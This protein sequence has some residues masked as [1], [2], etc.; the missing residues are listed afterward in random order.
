MF[1]SST[2]LPKFLHSLLFRISL[3]LIVVNCIGE[4]SL[5]IND[6]IPR[7]HL[8]ELF[9]KYALNDSLTERN[10]SA[11]IGNIYK[12]PFGSGQDV[13]FPTKNIL[14]ESIGIAEFHQLMPTLLYYLDRHE[15]EKVQEEFHGKV[16]VPRKDWKVWSA[17]VGAVLVISLSGLMVVALVPLMSR[18]VYNVV[19]QFL[20]ALSVGSLIGDSFL[21]LIPHALLSHGD[22]ES[23]GHSHDAASMDEHDSFVWKALIVLLGI[24]AF[25]I[26]ERLTILFQNS[27]SNRKLK[28]N[29]AISGDQ[30]SLMGQ[31]KVVAFSNGGMQV[32]PP[33]LPTSEQ[34]SSKCGDKAASTVNSSGVGTTNFKVPKSSGQVERKPVTP[35]H[36]TT[37]TCID[38]GQEC[39][40][41]STDAGNVCSSDASI[42][43]NLYY[44][45]NGLAASGLISDKHLC[46]KPPSRPLDNARCAE[47][48]TSEV[49]NGNE[50]SE[51]E[52]H[53]DVNACN[54]STA[55]GENGFVM[56]SWNIRETNSNDINNSEA[57]NGGYE[58]QPNGKSPPNGSF[59]GRTSWSPGKN[60]HEGHSHQHHHHHHHH[61]HHHHFPRAFPHRKKPHGHHHGHSHDLSSVRAIAY[62]IIA[63]DG[64]H[65]F[66]DGIAIGA[67]FAESLQGGLS[68]A[69][70][71]LCHELPHELGDFAVLLHAGMS[72]K[73]ALFYNTLSSIL[74]SAGMILGVL[75]GSVPYVNSWLFLLTAGMFVYIALVDMMPELTTNRL[76]GYR[77]CHLPSV[78]FFWQNMGMLIGTGIM[79]IIARLESPVA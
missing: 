78:L 23:N 61:G 77:R 44:D 28:R 62:T 40:S 13:C 10:F 79:F 17:S 31:P 51:S 4:Q 3:I 37:D 71:V 59:N 35:K 1:G 60:S 9:S 68:T 7:R 48:L 8:Q 67:S 75:L 16:S 72:V 2:L 76:S 25:F 41:K 42:T 30:P 50:V 29:Q 19:T 53:R 5:L 43:G 39:L 18:N 32:I 73:A 22:D 66:C 21:H 11:L 74:C 47:F 55:L 69:L 70:A 56:Q 58:G 49:C 45:G 57:G 65:N 34:P 6:N 14:N 27:A 26:T 36:C 63:G 15:C 52:N 64:L 46:N 38:S 12:A 33:Q 24:Y 20:I 54:S